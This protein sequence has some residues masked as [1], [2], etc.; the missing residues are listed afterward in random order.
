MRVLLSFVDTW[1]R[2]PRIVRS[3]RWEGV[4]FFIVF[5]VVTLMRIV[6]C[7]NNCLADA[8][9]DFCPIVLHFSNIL[10]SLIRWYIRDENITLIT[11]ALMRSVEPDNKPHSRFWFCWFSFSFL[12]PFV[13][14][15]CAEVAIVLQVGLPCD[16]KLCLFLSA[17]EKP[18]PDMCLSIFSLVQCCWLQLQRSALSGQFFVLLCLQIV[19]LGWIPSF[20]C[21]AYCGR[22]LVSFWLLWC[23]IRAGSW[24]CPVYSHKWINA[25]LWRWWSSCESIRYCGSLVG[26][27]GWPDWS[28]VQ[29]TLLE[30]MWNALHCIFC[31]NTGQ[32]L[33]QSLTIFHVFA[34]V[35]SGFGN[36]PI[37]VSKCI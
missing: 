4:C 21:P 33:G 27:C 8:H 16:V 26:W 10:E 12:L 32:L 5:H 3:G 22:W 11:I 15:L 24:S 34:I 13:R 31:H 25:P 29:Y 1:V 6:V 9:V 14:F 28:N 17:L 20:V 37:S 36:F 30:I 7:F 19:V 2:A 35:I 18:G 23:L